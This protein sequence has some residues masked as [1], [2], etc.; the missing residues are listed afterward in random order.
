M[1]WH[2]LAAAATN[3]SIMAKQDFKYEGVGYNG[4]HLAAMPFEKFKVEVEHHFKS[5]SNAEER[6]KD[7]YDKI[8]KK[9]PQTAKAGIKWTAP[10]TEEEA[11]KALEDRE[12]R[13]VETKAQPSLP[14]QVA[15]GAMAV[16]DPG[17]QGDKK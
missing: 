11:A 7:L 8:Q 5:G 17:S 3:F 9:Y 14:G 10:A 15:G 2:A 6:M 4:P 12:D 16:A 13:P 1:R